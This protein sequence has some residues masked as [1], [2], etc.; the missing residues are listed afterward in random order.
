M[1]YQNDDMDELFRRAADGYPLKMQEG[2]WD[3]VAAKISAPIATA[4]RVSEQNN[5]RNNYKIL[6][7][8]LLLLIGKGSSL[9]EFLFSN[10]KSLPILISALA[11][12]S[13][14]GAT[15]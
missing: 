10:M 11:F 12:N 2:N 13:G 15:P 5:K 4:A 6:T 3:A 1:Q 14:L 8:L 9:F 7:L